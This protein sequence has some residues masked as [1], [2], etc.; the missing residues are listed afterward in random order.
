MQKS[1]CHYWH[2][3]NGWGTNQPARPYTTSRTILPALTQA[4]TNAGY[5][6]RNVRLV[7]V[8]IDKEAIQNG[9]TLQG[10]P[11]QFY[12]L[13]H[14]YCTYDF[15]DQCPHRMACAKCDFYR[16][17]AA[18]QE[19]LKEAHTNLLRMVQAIPLTEDEQL[20]VKDGLDAI[21]SLCVRL[22][23]TPTPAGP[24]PRQLHST[25]GQSIVLLDDV[26]VVSFD[27]EN[28]SSRIE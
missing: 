3:R 2:Y 11:W 4:Y 19:Q 21:S 14:G 27:S 16:P 6:G 10:E 7:E 17:K 20:A 1:Q 24:T 5:F 28:K 22:A 12:D 26:S 15:F 23:D 9:S 13:G 8:L 25:P 18:T